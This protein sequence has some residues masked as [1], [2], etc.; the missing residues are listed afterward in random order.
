MSREYRQ[1]KNTGGHQP[2]TLAA[3]LVDAGCRTRDG[4][5]LLPAHR[6][7]TILSKIAASL[8]D[9]MVRADANADRKRNQR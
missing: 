8:E 6:A 9:A 4:D 1:L 7:D 5:I 3:E 2:T